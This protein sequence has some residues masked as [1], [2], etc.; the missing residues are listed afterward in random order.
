MI[1]QENTA[2]SSLHEGVT[3]EAHNRQRMLDT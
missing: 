1:L 2:R 3:Q